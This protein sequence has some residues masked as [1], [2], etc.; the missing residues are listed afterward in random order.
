MFRWGVVQV[1]VGLFRWGCSGGGGG[2]ADGGVQRGEGSKGANV[3]GIEWE[4]RG[5]SWRGE[6]LTES[7][8]NL[9]SGFEMD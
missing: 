5:K 2:G 7:F 9:C 3:R 4:Q 1:V 6:N 8:C